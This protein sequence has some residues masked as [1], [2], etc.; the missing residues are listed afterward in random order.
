MRDRLAGSRHPLL[1]GI[2]MITINHETLKMPSRN[3][4]G[5]QTQRHFQGMIEM[6]LA[7][8]AVLSSFR[9]EEVLN[10]L[11][12]E[13]YLIYPLVIEHGTRKFPSYELP[14]SS[15]LSQPRLMTDLRASTGENCPTMTG[16]MRT[17]MNPFKMN[18]HG[19]AS[20][21]ACTNIYVGIK[22]L[23]YCCDS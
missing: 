19:F 17:P 18:H 9:V 20:C 22:Y 2:T 10:H 6:G 7:I 21:N 15:G 4:S 5:P 11:Q 8:P 1:S 12:C 3:E 14:W 13:H 23:H 16:V